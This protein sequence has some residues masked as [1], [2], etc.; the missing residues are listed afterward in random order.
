[1]NSAALPAWCRHLPNGLPPAGVDLVAHG[2]LTRAW[3]ARWQESPS[4]EVIRLLDGTTVRAQELEER[5]GAVAGRM[6][7]AGL[8]AGDRILFSAAGSVDLVIAYVAAQRLGLVVVPMN[9]GYREREVTH[10]VSSVDPAAAIIDNAA[11][12]RTVASVRPDVLVTTPNVEWHSTSSVE[13]DTADTDDPALICH[14]SG[15]TGRPKGAVLTTG[16]L[17]ASA[18][19]V[20]IAWRWDPDDILV[21]ALPLFHLHGLG[22]GLHGTL[23]AGASLVLLDRF[24]PADVTAAI[25]RFSATM[26]FGVPTMY[27]RLSQDDTDESAMRSLRLCVSGSAPL[28]ASLHAEFQRRFGQRI[29]ERYGMTET[30][31]NLSN[32][33]DGD[34]RG[35]TVGFPLPGVDIRLEAVGTDPEITEIQ[36]R[37]PNVFRGYWH[38]PEATAETF[39]PDGWFKTG[40]LGQ[41]DDDGYYTI[42]GRLKQLIITGG[43]NVYPREVEDVLRAMPGVLDVAVVGIPSP[44]WGETVGAYVVADHALDVNEILAFASDRLASYKLPRSVTFI[45]KIPRNELGK[46]SVGQLIA[47][48]PEID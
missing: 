36:V 8:S 24:D 44:E 19:A 22:V 17:L 12:A 40:D 30:V 23:V 38:D 29:L 42:T 13:L 41:I 37:G 46:L 15:T 31:M 45:D 21:L 27:H 20:R 3:L 14:T 26:F 34:R 11:H 32:P 7:A 9:T 39:T 1:M 43:Y 48:R 2:S 10:I 25:R 33:Y 18:E 5:S 16:N 47:D 4:T 35:G 28:P 6:A